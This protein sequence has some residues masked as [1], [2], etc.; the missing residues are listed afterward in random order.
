MKI[1]Y[2]TNVRLPTQ[3]AHGFQIMKMCEAFAACGID[4][5][6]VVPFRQNEIQSDPFAYWQAKKDFTITYIGG[7][8][9]LQY[10]FIPR[11][12]AFLANAILFAINTTRYI[13]VHK[14]FNI[15]YTRDREVAFLSIF[16]KRKFVWEIHFL[17][18]AMFLYN[19]IFKRVFLLIA[20]TE[21]LKKFLTEHGVAD[22]KIIV[23]PDAVDLALFDTTADRKTVRKRFGIPEDKFVVLY[24][25]QLFMWKG[26]GTLISAVSMLPNNFM[27]VV[28]GGDSFGIASLPKY[29]GNNLIFLGQRPMREIPEL[30]KAAD[31]LVLPNSG[32]QKISKYYT[33]PLKLFEYMASGVPMVVSELPSLQEIVSEDDVF[34][35]ESD[36]ASDLARTIRE[37][38]EHQEDAKNRA[39]HA[40]EKV[41]QYTWQRRAKYIYDILQNI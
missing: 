18:R 12:I 1:T 7:S 14:N 17:P 36:N 3:K 37:V 10:K 41:K 38:A 13:F 30:L 40:E 19:F 9:F 25:G 34:F 20:I 23:S 15:I 8:D 32:K 33:S 39:T 5:E 28:V 11:K 27:T 31:V 6:L 16:F 21:H 24:A 4:V 35:F 26:V 2:I 22:D 29:S